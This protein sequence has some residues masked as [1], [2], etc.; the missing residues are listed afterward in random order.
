M[1]P[2]VRQLFQVV[3]IGLGLTFTA[4]MCL[5]QPPK[6]SPQEALIEVTTSTL[7]HLTEA[8]TNDIFLNRDDN[9]SNLLPI[10]PQFSVAAQDPTFNRPDLGD[11]ELNQERWRHPG[12]TG[13]DALWRNQIQRANEI[14]H[15][16][17]LR[18]MNR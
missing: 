12:E 14:L 6:T 1:K 11:S 15:N 8:A 10:S 18:K 5:H 16:A 4:W 9:Q 3:F 17:G 7:P 2:F 13:T